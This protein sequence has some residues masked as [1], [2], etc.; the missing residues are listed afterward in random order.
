[1]KII[2]SRKGFDGSAGGHASP[3]LPDGKM[4]SLPIPSSLDSLGYHEIAAPDRKSV[5]QIIDE[6][7]AGAEIGHKGAHLDPDLVRGARP[8]LPGWRPSLGQ[9]GA[10][11][12]HLRNEGVSDGDLFLFFGWF[13]HAEQGAD[14]LHF[15]RGSNG[16]HAIFGYL[17]I[18]KT[19]RADAHADFP[20]W[21]RDHPHAEPSRMAKSSNTVY[22]ATRRLSL[23]PSYPGAGVFRFSDRNVLT[24][25]GCSRGRWGLDSTLFRHVKTSYHKESAWRDEY[26][27]S[28]PRAQEYVIHADSPI[29]A[30]ASRMIRSSRLWDLD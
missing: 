17:E 29:I 12:R 21:L 14:G 10:A 20:P 2:L 5:G 24:K 22:V 25:N 9:I 26:F 1:L 23:H 3:I 18:G 30:W 15:C 4:L 11:G 8:R 6:L 7:A 19:L 28:Y 13:R 16:F 27:Q